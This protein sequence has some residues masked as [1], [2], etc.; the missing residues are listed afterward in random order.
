MRA[1]RKRKEELE[2]AEMAQDLATRE[3]ES[4]VHQKV[5]E[6]QLRNLTH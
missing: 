6:K 4:R 1:L 3:V 5:Q 2:A